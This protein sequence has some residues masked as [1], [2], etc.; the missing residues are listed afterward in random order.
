MNEKILFVDDD[1]NVLS[2]YVRI[3]RRKYSVETALGGEEGLKLM[4]QHGPYAVVV[5]DMQ[6]PR[7]DGTQFLAAVRERY[8]TTVRMLLTGYA[9]VS[10]AID[11]VNRG[12]LY[13][14][15]T[16][17]CSIP[18]LTAAVEAAL[19]QHR[20]IHSERELL[21]KTLRSS[22]RVFAEVLAIVNP[23]A[24]GRVQRLQKI[25][26]EIAKE[27]GETVG[28]EIDI[29]VTL[30]QLGYIGISERVLAAAERG[31]PL[32]DDEQR[33]LE[34]APQMALNLIRDIPRLEDARDII[35]MIDSPV[36]VDNQPLGS[37]IIRLARDFDTILTY[38]I[39]RPQAMDQLKQNAYRYDPRYFE[40]LGRVVERQSRPESRQVTLNEL[41]AD[42]VLE[43]D[44]YSKSGRFLLRQGNTISAPMRMRLESM[45][46]AGEVLPTFRVLVMSGR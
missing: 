3:L 34:Q 1:H 25:I 2:A 29:A 38:G 24:F 42:M 32:E 7:M 20:L 19:E 21:D 13:R 26:S 8:P 17:P 28:W 30:M 10:N 46:N 18:D 23:T 11:A 6:M 40:A 16:K 31:K 35:A 27:C 37:R 33:Q 41:T 12:G 39:P 22:V 36:A 9:D 44:L 5:S 45:V 43:N 14:F 15:L 4:E